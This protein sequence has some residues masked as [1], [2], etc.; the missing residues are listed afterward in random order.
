MPARSAGRALAPARL[1]CLAAAIV[2]VLSVGAAKAEVAADDPRLIRLLD[3]LCRASALAEG[4][5]DAGTASLCRCSAPVIADHLTPAARQ[6]FVEQNRAPD[7]PVYDDEAAT[8][9]DVT[10]RCPEAAAP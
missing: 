9:A 10:A 1:S 4:G 6:S 5:L 7:G 2:L 3:E 8:L